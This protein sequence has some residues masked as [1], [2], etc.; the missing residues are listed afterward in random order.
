VDFLVFILVCLV[1]HFLL[2]G[3]V[4]ELAKHG[5]DCVD[6]LQANAYNTIHVVI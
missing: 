5:N 4:A 2:T 3:L 1:H 6:A